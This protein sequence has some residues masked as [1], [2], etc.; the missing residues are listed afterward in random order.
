MAKI[1]GDYRPYIR[2][3]KPQLLKKYGD[4]ILIAVTANRAPLVCFRNTGFKLLSEAWYNKK[5]DDKTE[6]RR[7]IV[8]TAAAIVIEDILSRVYET[9]HHPPS[10]NFFQESESDIP[11]TLRVFLDDMILKNKRASLE[12]WKK[13]SAKSAYKSKFNI[14]SLPPTE[15]A[16]RQHS[17]RT[18]HQVQKWYGNEQN[19]EQWG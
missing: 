8:T 14:A 6:E 19:A 2:M 10:D 3:V 12:K 11:E 16:A 13:K 4:D 5:S 18:Y 7:R 15:A 1:E 9:K 17:F